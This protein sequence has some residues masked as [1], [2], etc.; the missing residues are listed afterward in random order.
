[1]KS[2]DFP[3]D[4]MYA[5][6]YTFHT[7]WFIFKEN[8]IRIISPQDFSGVPNL[9]TLDLSGNK[10]DDESFSHG[11][12]SVSTTSPR[13]S[14]MS[15]LICHI[16][17]F[18]RDADWLMY[19]M[20]SKPRPFKWNLTAEKQTRLFRPERRVQPALPTAEGV[21]QL[22]FVWFWMN[23]F[24]QKTLEERRRQNFNT[25]PFAWW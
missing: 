10:L 21:S 7:M 16:T 14:L 6:N 1:M 11:P 25:F 13:F 2:S 5:Y 20:Q 19:V 18:L 23:I 17:T 4:M 8:H 3:D 24:V 12:L 22:P 9:D 15:C